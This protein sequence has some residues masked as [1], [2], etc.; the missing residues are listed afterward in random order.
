MA[1]WTVSG[2]NHR[3]TGTSFKGIDQSTSHH[4]KTSQREKISIEK[5]KV[6]RG[7]EGKRG[8]GLEVP[9][10]ILFSYFV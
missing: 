9:Q 4:V 6:R 2:L 10:Q 3:G 5:W 7:G 8:R 1:D